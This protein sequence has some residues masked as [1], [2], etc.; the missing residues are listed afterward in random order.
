MPFLLTNE[1][2]KTIL[3][4]HFLNFVDSDGC[5]LRYHS[6]HHLSRTKNIYTG[7]MIFFMTWRLVTL[8]INFIAR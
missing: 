5:L 4:V 2:T 8:F 6:Q 7:K 1:S 3:F